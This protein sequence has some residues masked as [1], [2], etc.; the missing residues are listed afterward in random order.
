MKSSFLST[1]EQRTPITPISHNRN[2]KLSVYYRLN[3]GKQKTLSNLNYDVDL[4]GYYKV[5]HKSPT[6]VCRNGKRNQ[7]EHLVN[8]KKKD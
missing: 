8:L 7:T 2:K 1:F 5:G 6:K 3:K 4:G